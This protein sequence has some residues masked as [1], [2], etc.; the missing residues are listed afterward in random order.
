MVSC[1]LCGKKIVNYNPVFNQLVIND[2]ISVDFCES[3]IDKFSKWRMNVL[4]KLFP[5]KAAKRLK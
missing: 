1:I 5:T 4:A 3:C 2:S